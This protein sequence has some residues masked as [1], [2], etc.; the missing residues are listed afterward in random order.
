MA[1]AFRAPLSGRADDERSG[2][3]ARPSFGRLP[4][5]TPTGE[6][7]AKRVRASSGP[8]LRERGF[9]PVPVPP[10]R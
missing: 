7:S 1:R 4:V 5:G 6:R 3:E 9:P 8:A 2:A 10:K